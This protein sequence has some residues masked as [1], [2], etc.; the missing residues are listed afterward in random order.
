MDIMFMFAIAA[1]TCTSLA[2]PTN[3]IITYATDTIAPFN[4]QT[5]ATYSCVAGYGLSGGDTVRTCE[6]ASGGGS[7]VGSAPTCEGTSKI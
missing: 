7:W 3:G 2:I 1:T 4:Y 6:T 5:M